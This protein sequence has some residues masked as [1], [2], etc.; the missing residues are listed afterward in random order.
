MTPAVV[1]PITPVLMENVASEGVVPGGV[2][3]EGVVPEGVV[4]EGVI[5]SVMVSRN[6]LRVSGGHS[7]HYAS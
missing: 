7:I 5:A 6:S 2:A 4:P 1:P 3:P